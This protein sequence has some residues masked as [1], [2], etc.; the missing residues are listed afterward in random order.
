VHVSVAYQCIQ[1]VGNIFMW[2][3]L[4][5]N[6]DVIQ[7]MTAIRSNFNVYSDCQ[8]TGTGSIDDPF[9]LAMTINTVTDE[10]NRACGV[11]VVGGTKL[12]M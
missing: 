3:R 9:T 1:L 4:I 2:V 7:G 8:S 6:D 11:A 10:R 5:N 12:A